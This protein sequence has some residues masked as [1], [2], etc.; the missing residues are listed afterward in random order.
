MVNFFSIPV[1]FW[2]SLNLKLVTI[3]D[4]GSSLSNIWVFCQMNFA[5]NII[6]N[7]SQQV[8]VKVMVDKTLCCLS[9]V[10]ALTNPF[11][12]RQLW[13]DLVDLSLFGGPWMVIGYFNAVLGAHEKS[14]GCPPMRLA[15]MEFKRMSDSCDLIHLDTTGAPFTWSNG[16]RSRGHIELRLDRAFFNS[17]WLDY[18]SI[19]NCQTLPRLVSDHN[20]LI[21]TALKWIPSGPRPFRF[22]SMWL[23]HESFMEVLSSCWKSTMV[24]GC[25]MLVILSKL[26]ALKDC[27]KCWNKSVF[28]DIHA[29]VDEA[30]SILSQVRSVI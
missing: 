21:F 14:G 11:T 20:P 23:L 17:S 24:M 30:R 29:T 13:Q 6:S 4:R 8:S 18:W 16:W 27:L 26:R 25:P 28:G 22:Q 15:C 9:F 5:P 7:T 1:F 19:S 2:S 3:N 12:R 10:Y